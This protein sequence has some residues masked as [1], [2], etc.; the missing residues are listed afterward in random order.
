MLHRSI[1]IT[2]VA[3]L[4]AMLSLMGTAHAAPTPVVSPPV[5]SMEEYLTEGSLSLSDLRGVDLNSRANKHNMVLVE[6]KK[7]SLFID[8]KTNWKPSSYRFPNPHYL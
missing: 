2:F 8:P 7:H 3:L 5:T 1:S 6:P 4:A